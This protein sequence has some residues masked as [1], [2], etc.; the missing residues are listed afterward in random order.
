MNK[1]QFLKK[2]HQTTL[3][4]HKLQTKIFLKAKVINDLCT[5]ILNLEIYKLKNT[6]VNE[7]LKSIILYKK[8]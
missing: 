5:K 1:Q 8:Y 7:S 3:N 4:Q 2:G 6:L